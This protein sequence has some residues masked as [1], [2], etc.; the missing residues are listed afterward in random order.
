MHITHRDI[1]CLFLLQLVGV[2]FSN[3][4]V[5]TQRRL[6]ADK[7]KSTLYI[8]K[9]TANWITRAQTVNC[10]DFFK[11]NNLL[12]LTKVFLRVPRWSSQTKFPFVLS[13]IDWQQP[14]HQLFHVRFHDFNQLQE[15][16]IYYSGI[17]FP[18]KKS[19][20]I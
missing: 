9:N 1:N 7:K 2:N 5:W 8:F 6:Q 13:Q 3:H 15:N 11:E 12:N 17:F 4:D 16:S 20:H 19:R 18:L 14:W 10:F